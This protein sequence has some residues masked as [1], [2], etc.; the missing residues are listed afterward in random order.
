MRYAFFIIVAFIPFVLG[1]QLTA[2]G[3]NAV[4]FTTYP[5][6]P[7]V[8]DPIFI[9]CNSGGTSKGA[10]TASSPG[11]TGP[12]NFSWYRWNDITN[13]F[14]DLILTE[15][16][17]ASSSLTN[18]DEG[19]YRVNI[20][21]GFNATLTAWIH[22]DMP[23]TLAQLQNRTCDY[24]ALR[25]IAVADTFFYHDP[26][27]GSPVKLPNAVRFLWSS[28]PESVIPFPDFAINPQTFTPPLEDVNYNLQVTD[29]FGC[30][31]ESSFFYESIHVKA[32]FTADPVDGEAPLEV[33]FTDKSIRG[34]Y[35]YRWDF[36]EKTPDGKEVPDWV[37]TEDSL[38]LFN[39]P[40][41]HKF[42]IPGKYSVSLTI[43]SNMHCIDS[44]R[45]EP[46]INVE[47]SELDIPNV[48][49]PDGDGI[50]DFFMVDSKSLRWL[51]VDVFSRSGVMVYRFAGDG[52]RLS[53]WQG[54]DGNV[55]DTSRKASP[56]V[57]F[58][59]IRAQGWDDIIY[60]TSEQ[61]GFVYLYR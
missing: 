60:N 49:S 53:Q 43:E 1:A 41:T 13:L 11:G 59:I 52:D 5:S 32:E 9:F 50:N 20:S 21:G 47:K 39:T 10:L 37:V 61:R 46:E 45:L 34:N 28:D 38:W 19:G 2:P 36:D 14:S 55:N 8:R 51:S 23:H 27:F 22:L 17:V 18:L 12:F 29:S 48:F 6:T 15:T 3:S 7:A 44:F 4:R 25:G 56:G 24:V 57:Y 35:R 33:V 30:V 58:Y 31:S 40:F 16:G 26:S 54:W 42:Y